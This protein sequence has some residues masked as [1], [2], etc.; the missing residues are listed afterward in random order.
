MADKSKKTITLRL[1][2]ESDPTEKVK[3]KIQHKE[4]IP[5]DEQRLIFDGQK[6]EDDC[7]LSGYNVTN[8]STLHLVIILRGGTQIFVKTLTGKMITL[9]VEPA[10]TIVN[11]KIKIQDKER[12]PP[13]QQ[14]L[15]F[16]GKKLEDSR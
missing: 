6:K 10:D 9:E 15:L 7:F 14:R 16:D 11:V 5:P 4:G 1:N 3:K 13:D 8:K 2:R 12:I